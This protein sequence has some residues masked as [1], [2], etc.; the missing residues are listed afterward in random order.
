MEPTG[1]DHWVSAPIA[2]VGAG[3]EIHDTDVAVWMPD[4]SVNKVNFVRFD[5]AVQATKSKKGG[6]VVG[7]AMAQIGGELSKEQE[8][9]S[10]IRFDIPLII[11]EHP[12]QPEQPP[13]SSP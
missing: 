12:W 13:K 5:V 10:R 11:A 9:V 3:H 7:V 2:V 1:R 6:G 4:G 8:V